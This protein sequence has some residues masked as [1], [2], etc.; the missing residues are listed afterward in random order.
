MMEKEKIKKWVSFWNIFA[1]VLVFLGFGMIHGSSKVEKIGSFM[2][3]L[4]SLYLI[5]VIA[6]SI[7]NKPEK[8]DSQN[9]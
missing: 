4:G 2:I 7:G 5:M 9:L 3:G 8:E 6:K 1:M